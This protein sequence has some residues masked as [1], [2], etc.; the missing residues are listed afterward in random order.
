[1]VE[2]DNTQ[3]QQEMAMAQEGMDATINQRVGAP[4]SID[5]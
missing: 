3:Q 4:G 1:M 2:V 5:T